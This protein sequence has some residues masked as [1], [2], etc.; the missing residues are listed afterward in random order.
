M[1]VLIR[2]TSESDSCF[3]ASQLFLFSSQLLLCTRPPSTSSTSASPAIPRPS[4]ATA[5]TPFAAPGDPDSRLPDPCS[6]QCLALGWPS[7]IHRLPLHPPRHGPPRI[8]QPFLVH[9]FH[10]L[11][12]LPSWLVSWLLSIP[13][14]SVAT[15]RMVTLHPSSAPLSN[16]EANQTHE[17]LPF[18]IKP[19]P[20]LSPCRVPAVSFPQM[21]R[22][23][24]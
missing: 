4:S 18:L 8:S 14:P 12:S 17:G 5:S 3:S 13:S 20:R 1:Y 23:T 9:R 22:R 10:P 6:R 2:R 15:T 11:P 21:S 24:P 19:R 16:P 7:L